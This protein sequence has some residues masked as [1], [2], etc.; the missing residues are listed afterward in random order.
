LKKVLL[1]LRLHFLSQTEVIINRETGNQQPVRKY[2][3]FVVENGRADLREV[4]VGL[5]SNSRA[6]ITGGIEVSDSVI[7]VGN[8]IVQDGQLVN[9]ID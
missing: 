6:Q 9:I 7:V 2:F 5:T 1:C 3:L 4:S 8:N